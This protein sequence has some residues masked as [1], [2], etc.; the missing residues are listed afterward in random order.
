MAKI[1]PEFGSD[2]CLS[3]EHR[4]LHD[5]VAGPARAVLPLKELPDWPLE[6]L[7]AAFQ[8]DTLQLGGSPPPAFPP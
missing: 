6:S 2:Q 3:V 7:K 1:V 5:D 4:A 8:F